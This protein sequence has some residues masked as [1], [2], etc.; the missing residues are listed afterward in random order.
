MVHI[1]GKRYANRA[2]PITDVKVYSNAQSTEL[3]LNGRSLGAK[4]DCPQKVCVWSAVALDEGTNALVARGVHSGGQVEDKTEWTL[5]SETRRH[6]VIDSGTLV[7]GKGKDRVL[8]SDNWF[9]GGSV[10]SLDTPADYG[11]P[12]KPAEIGGT[13]ERDALATY[14]QGTF[15]YRVPVADGRYRVT[16]WFATAA[17]QKAGTFDVKHGKKAL[18]REFQPAIPAM[19]AVAEAKAFTI[20]VKSGIALDFM[21]GTGEARVSMIEIEKL[22]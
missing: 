13:Q 2:Y 3:L 4:S 12:A 9:D 1:T 5:S 21:A 7:A 15:S 17:T 10:A 22:R 20:N 14:R 6:M 18:L 8:G 19:G 11:K 16:L